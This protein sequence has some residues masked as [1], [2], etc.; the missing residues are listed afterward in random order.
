VKREIWLHYL[1][2]VK[3]WVRHLSETDP[4][5]LEEQVVEL[6]PILRSEMQIHA[7]KDTVVYQER[8]IRHN[9]DCVQSVSGDSEEQPGRT[10]QQRWLDETF[11]MSTSSGNCLWPSR[12][13]F[14]SLC[15]EN[16]DPNDDMYT[17]RVANHPQEFA[18]D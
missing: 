17:I 7:W 14:F 2:G 3:E 16:G 10:C 12:C 15:H 5:L 18:N 1:G 6:P 9:R 4:A 8:Q 13:T 11:P